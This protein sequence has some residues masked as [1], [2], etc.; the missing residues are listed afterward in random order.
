MR[1]LRHAHMQHAASIDH[2]TIF[3]SDASRFDVEPQ[4][5]QVEHEMLD[6]GR[7]TTVLADR[8]MFARG[9]DLL[10]SVPEINRMIPHVDIWLP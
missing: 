4:Q 9:K 8:V 1:N 10:V 6:M 5:R 7:L 2:C 3:P